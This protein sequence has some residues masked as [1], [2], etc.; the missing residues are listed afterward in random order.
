MD[1]TWSTVTLF[2][3]TFCEGPISIISVC[4]PTV[5]GGARRVY[6][7]GLPTLFKRNDDS[8]DTGN[9]FVRAPRKIQ[10]IR[11]ETYADNAGAFS[12]RDARG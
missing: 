9:G 12:R 3:W 5:L 1:L 10:Y 11:M 6:K 4:L 8:A 7:N 2:E